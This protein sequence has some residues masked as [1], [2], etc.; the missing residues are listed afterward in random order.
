MA[1]TTTSWWLADNQIFSLQKFNAIVNRRR[2]M[3]REGYSY[4]PRECRR[5]GL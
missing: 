5:R 3:K 2:S 1:K 4:R